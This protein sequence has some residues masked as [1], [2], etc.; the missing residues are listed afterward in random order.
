MKKPFAL[1]LALLLLLPAV[2]AFA[3]EEPFEIT[4]FYTGT[5]DV[6]RN[7]SAL[8]RVFEEKTNTRLRVIEAADDADQKLATLLATGDEIDVFVIALDP[9][10]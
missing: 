4:I 9:E 2:P 10:K 5:G 6:D 3:E 1:L 8:L 7:E